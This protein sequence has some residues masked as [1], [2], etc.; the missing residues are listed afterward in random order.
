MVLNQ[1]EK[2]IRN[3]TVNLNTIITENSE[4]IQHLEGIRCPIEKSG[5][6]EV[7]GKCLFTDTISVILS[8]EKAYFHYC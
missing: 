8:S 7:L 1:T 6:F 5:Y 2:L 4:K 3:E